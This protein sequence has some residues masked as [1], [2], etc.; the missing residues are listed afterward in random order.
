VS[1]V[2]W[3]A[4]DLRTL[5]ETLE[6]LA[7]VTA[8]RGQGR[9]AAELFGS[10]EAVRKLTGVELLPWL[11]SSRDAS[12]DWVRMSLGS[13]GFDAAWQAG[14]DMPLNRIMDLAL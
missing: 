10:A 14:M 6:A 12:R 9:R 8:S 1:Q 5:P 7:T 2:L 11:R 13:S 3:A 4:R